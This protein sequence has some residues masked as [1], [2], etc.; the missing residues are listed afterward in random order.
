MPVVNKPQYVHLMSRIAK[1]CDKEFKCEKNLNNILILF[2]LFCILLRYFRL[3]FG[4]RVVAR[5]HGID[6]QNRISFSWQAKLSAY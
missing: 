1:F 4:L 6:I 2:A 5:L 3:C